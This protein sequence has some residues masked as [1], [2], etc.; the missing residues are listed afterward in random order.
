VPWLKNNCK[1]NSFFTTQILDL[2]NACIASEL[3]V[4][5]LVLQHATAGNKDN[6]VA[7]VSMQGVTRQ[8]SQLTA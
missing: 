8:L 5:Q 3:P 1:Q 2:H 7:A 6:Q 4:H